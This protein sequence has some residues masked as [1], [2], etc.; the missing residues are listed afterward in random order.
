MQS[1]IFKYVITCIKENLQKVSGTQFTITTEFTAANKPQIKI[2]VIDLFQCSNDKTGQKVIVNEKMYEVPAQYIL[3]MR[4]LFAG[5]KLEEI[6]SAYGS[7]AAFFK[8]NNNFDLGEYNWH[9]NTTTRFYVEP[10]IRKDF[11]DKS[12][13]LHLDY[14]IELQLNSNKEEKVVRVEKKVLNTNQI[15]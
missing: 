9:A 10:V 4:I 12:E 3:I 8:D 1:D 6:L 13:Y 15:K 2:D 7:V 14:R 5:K 11:N